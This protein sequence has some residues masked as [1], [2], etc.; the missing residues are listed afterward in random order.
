MD[1]LWN[2]EMRMWSE[3]EERNGTDILTVTVFESFEQLIHD[4]LDLNQLH[5]IGVGF[6]ILQEAP[7]NV[8]KDKMAFA[9]SSKHIQKIDDVLMI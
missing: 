5:A 7:V 2:E 6:Q 3:A 8:F 4:F 1:D 9:L